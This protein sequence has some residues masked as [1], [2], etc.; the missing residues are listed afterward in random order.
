MQQPISRTTNPA[1]HDAHQSPI[2]DPKAEGSEVGWKVAVAVVG[3]Y[4]T[5]VTIVGLGI[6]TVRALGVLLGAYNPQIGW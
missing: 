4:L 2:S 3:G 5:I 6:L 1:V